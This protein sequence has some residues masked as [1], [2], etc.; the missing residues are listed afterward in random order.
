MAETHGL[1]KEA[2][3]TLCSMVYVVQQ[4]ILYALN[5]HQGQRY[6]KNK[7]MRILYPSTQHRSWVHST[8]PCSREPGDGLCWLTFFLIN[9]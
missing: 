4:W 3:K 7:T 1:T 5:K 2:I 6:I 8:A 9:S